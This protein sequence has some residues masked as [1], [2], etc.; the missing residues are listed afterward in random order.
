MPN[1]QITSPAWMCYMITT[2]M[3]EFLAWHLLGVFYNR[4]KKI[5]VCF[6]GRW[7]AINPIMLF[8]DLLQPFCCL[9][10]LFGTKVISSNGC[11]SL[12]SCVCNHFRYLRSIIYHCMNN[13]ME[14]L[15]YGSVY[16]SIRRM[17]HVCGRTKR[18]PAGGDKGLITFTSFSGNSSLHAIIP[19][20]RLN[21]GDWKLHIH[22]V[23]VAYGT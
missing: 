14:I 11:S 18:L 13:C 15:K 3:Q 6:G 1:K 5:C 23:L 8:W 10:K 7:I 22:P 21:E 12:M 20:Y 19:L 17:Q 16:W 9:S 4:E 2:A